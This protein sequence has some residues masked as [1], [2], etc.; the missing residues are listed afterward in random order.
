[1]APKT[2]RNLI[3]YSQWWY[4][5]KGANWKHPHGPESS[6]EGMDS[7]PVVHIAYSDAQAI[8]VGVENVYQQRQN[9]NGL[10]EED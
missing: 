6:I 5:I 7:Y 3:D 4:W 1:M 8:Q 10:Q 9:G 2:A